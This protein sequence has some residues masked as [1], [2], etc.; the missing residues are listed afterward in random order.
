MSAQALILVSAGALAAA[1]LKIAFDGWRQ[2]R[3]ARADLAWFF[4]GGSFDVPPS[5]RGRP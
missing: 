4:D 2:Q 3:Q 5:V 1:F